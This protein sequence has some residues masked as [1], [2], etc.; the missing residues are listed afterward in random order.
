MQQTPRNRSAPSAAP[1]DAAKDARINAAAEEGALKE[2][3]R[4]LS[5]MSGRAWV[6]RTVTVSFL[7]ALA[8]VLWK[9]I[10]ILCGSEIPIVV[11]LSES[12]APGYARGDLLLL[13]SVAVRPL[14]VGDIVVFRRAGRDIPIVHRVHRQHV[15][16]NGTRFILTKG[17]NNYGDDISLYNPGQFF[18]SERDVM[19]RSVVYLPFVGQF[20]ILMAETKY[21][22]ESVIGLLV[23]IVF[24][25]SED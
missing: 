17:D 15:D 13:S 16:G 6:S 5:A 4:S 22:R 11:V 24:V 19:G 21:L 12:M 14:E 2:T 1:K 7:A 10:I 25:T 9:C 18:I 3:W 23:L 8:V 20:T